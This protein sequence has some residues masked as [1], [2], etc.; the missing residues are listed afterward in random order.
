MKLKRMSDLFWFHNISGGVKIASLISDTQ[1]QS[2]S[3]AF[4]FG[5]CLEFY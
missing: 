1:A 4:S 5:S 2:F 3:L